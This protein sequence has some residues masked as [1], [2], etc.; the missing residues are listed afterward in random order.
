MSRT[1]AAALGIVGRGRADRGHTQ[2]TQNIDL[3]FLAIARERSGHVACGE[4][5]ADSCRVAATSLL[6][7]LSGRIL[8]KTA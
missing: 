8:K 2:F 3:E 5:F 4:A 1:Q 7:L 6:S